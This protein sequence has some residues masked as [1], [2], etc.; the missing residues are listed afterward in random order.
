ML[1][2]RTLAKSQSDN[3]RP[4]KQGTV[5]RVWDT[6]TGE[7]VTE[8]RRG[9]DKADINCIA[10][11]RNAQRLCVSS[12]KVRHAPVVSSRLRISTCLPTAGSLC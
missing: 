2:W 9:K 12:D 3:R 8:L 4:S 7:R 1:I 11:S 6:A 5:I 10:F